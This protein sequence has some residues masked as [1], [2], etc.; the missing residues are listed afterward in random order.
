M[1]WTSY[2]EFG[3]GNISP[4]SFTFGWAF[5]RPPQPPFSWFALLTA[6]AKACTMIFCHMWNI[7]EWLVCSLFIKIVY[8]SY[9]QQSCNLHWHM[10]NTDVNAK[11]NCELLV[12]ISK[13][14][15][16]QKNFLFFK[17]FLFLIF[18]QPLRLQNL[19][20]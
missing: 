3:M 5:H 4:C 19:Q 10:A 12:C 8:Y 14:L 2:L 9:I 6:W 18:L 11:S 16:R 15:L 13:I 20:S 7:L 17:N 1:F